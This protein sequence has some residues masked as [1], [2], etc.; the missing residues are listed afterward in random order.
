M[1]SRHDLLRGEFKETYQRL[2]SELRMYFPVKTGEGISAGWRRAQWLRGRLGDAEDYA[3]LAV[4]AF[5][6]SHGDVAQL[7]AKY[8]EERGA[9]MTALKQLFSPS[10]AE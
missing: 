5:E 9:D 4:A 3:M 1:H 10:K 6:T 2:H 7:A 8:A